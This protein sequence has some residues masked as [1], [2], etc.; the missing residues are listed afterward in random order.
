MNTASPRIP[1]AYALH[2]GN[3]YGTERMA[4]YTAAG[5]AGHF[6]PIILAPEGAG[7][8]EA[9]ARGFEAIGCN[10][11]G[12]FSSAVR[13]LLRRH[14]RLAFIATGVVHSSICLAWNQLYRR[15]VSHLHLVHGGASEKLS[16][17]RKKLLNH[18]PV[19]F[20]GVSQFVRAR[21][22]AHG[23]DAERIQVIENFLPEQ[24]LSLPGRQPFG[25]EP[26]R[27]LIVIS[28]LDPEKRVSLLLEAFERSPD[29]QAVNVHVY[30]SGRDSQ[31]L[32]ERAARY[33][34]NIRFDG[35]HSDLHPVLTSSDLL[36][37]LCPEEPFGLAVIEAMAAGVPVLVPDSG[38]AGSLVEDNSTGFHFRANDALS[39]AD[40]IRRILACGSECLNQIV[41]RARQ[42]HQNRF[43][44]AQRIQQYDQLLMAGFS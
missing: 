39:L 13:A 27:R 5:L 12:Q 25:D 18:F 44:A 40:R 16:Y 23:V 19:Q 43:S 14:Q 38:G 37:H 32:R 8:K 41:A 34:P 20:V 31:A 9:R 33:S 7:L 29:L 21:L 17:G 2:S 4:L 26:L 35:F 36:V 11:S 22:I 30:G 28:R 1:L 15:K 42:L 24:Q 3:L 10:G 6:E